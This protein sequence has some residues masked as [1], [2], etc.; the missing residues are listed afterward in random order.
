[1]QPLKIGVYLRVSTDDQ[2][3]VFE[4]SLE[5]QKYR[6]TEFIQYKNVQLQN[7]WGEIVDYYIEEGVSAGTTNRPEYQRLMSDI[8]KGRVNMILVTDLSRLSRNLLDFCNLI[9]ELEEYKAGYLSM[10][11]QFDT[12][13]SIGRMIVYIIIALGQFE[14]ETT[15]E[16]VSINCNTR[17]LKGFLNGGVAPLGYQRDPEKTGILIANQ[18]EADTVRRIFNV[19]L[20]EGSRS[21]AI[22][23]LHASKIFPRRH[24]RRFL[25]AEE[26]EAPKWTV[27]TL[28]NVL[29]NP[30]YVGIR[31]V[32]KIYKD[33][34]PQHLKPWQQY[35]KVKAA[36]EGILDE[37]IFYEA[38]RVLEEAASLERTRNAKGERRIFLLSGL[39][40]CG[41]TGLPL[42][43]QAGHS[44]RGPVYRYYHYAR[45]P[46]NLKVVRPRLNADELEEKVIK[47]F[48]TALSTQGYFEELENI[49]KTKA[50]VSNK[51]SKDEYERLRK[52]LQD[53]SQRISVIWANQARMQLSEAALK[54]ASE[55]LNRL[56][57]EKQSL[58]AQIAQ[59]DLT[60]FNTDSP[61]HQ[62]LFVENQ[63]RQCL[64]GWAKATPSLRKRLLRRVIK[65][66]VV[67]T[68]EIRLTFWT[69]L[70]EQRETFNHWNEYE[71]GKAENVVPIRRYA[72]PGKDQNLSVKSSG[73]VK[74]GS[75]RRT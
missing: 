62:A 21:R 9:Q 29:R 51:D 11:E 12:S 25:E 32:N 75:E 39:L 13:T 16:R 50:E 18:D 34:N 53:T 6:A 47:E 15:S 63:M 7:P 44:A 71:S 1:M 60:A 27:Q 26:I 48:K 73:N 45:K 57:Q 66:I 58:E 49:L 14:R 24:S 31:E 23:K 56:A 36:W 43:G 4:G 52:A 5:S 28:G 64:Q 72:P 2:V 67:T 65:N 54:L 55:E 61:R 35:K 68:D 59:I 41:E 33:E 40:N 69:S 17:A 20:E 22:S 3:N 10:K 42:V 19:F 8:R 38:Q 46:E 70:E 30:S 37:N 74:I